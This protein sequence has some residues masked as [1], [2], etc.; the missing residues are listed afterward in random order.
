MRRSIYLGI[1][2]FEIVLSFVRFMYRALCMTTLD[3]GW[4]MFWK[5]LTNECYFRKWSVCWTVDMWTVWVY[6]T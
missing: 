1:F 5:A 6:V 3:C 4:N 2:I